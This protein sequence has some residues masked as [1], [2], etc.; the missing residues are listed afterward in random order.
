MSSNLDRK[1]SKIIKKFNIEIQA[2]PKRVR[3]NRLCKYS[4]GDYSK[5]ILQFFMDRYSFMNIPSQDE[6]KLHYY[7]HNYLKNKRIT[8]QVTPLE[9]VSKKRKVIMSYSYKQ[10]YSEYIRINDGDQHYIKQ[11]IENK[12]LEMGILNTSIQMF[13]K[14]L[15]PTNKFYVSFVITYFEHY[16]LTDKFISFIQEKFSEWNEDH[17]IGYF[18]TKGIDL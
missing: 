12:I 6:C 2:Y 1:V 14:S 16:S 11:K 18:K 13:H 17:G 3:A 9:S 4:Y 10:H 8:L 7:L 5:S 15:P